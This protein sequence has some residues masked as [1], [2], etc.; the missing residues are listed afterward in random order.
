MSV[1]IA[2]QQCG[3]A[4]EQA[5]KISRLTRPEAVIAARAAG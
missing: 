1:A 5:T 2:Q 3:S 4:R